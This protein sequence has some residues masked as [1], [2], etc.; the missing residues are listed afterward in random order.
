MDENATVESVINTIQKDYHESRP[1]RHISLAGAALFNTC[2]PYRRLPHASEIKQAAVEFKEVAP[3]YY[4]TEYHVSI[5]IE[6][7]DS[8]TTIDRLLDGRH[9]RC[10]SQQDPHPVAQYHQLLRET[11]QGSGQCS[12]IAQAIHRAV[13]SG[14]SRCYWSL[15]PE[16]FEHMAK[17][18]PT[19]TVIN[20]WDKDFT[21]VRLDRLSS[22]LA[23]YLGSLGVA[24]E[25][26]V[27]TCFSKSAW[28]AVEN[29]VNH[30]LMLRARF[31]KKNE[32]Q[33]DFF[34]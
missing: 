25:K 12:G 19:A 18:Y 3:A 2:L 27:S 5:N 9:D 21:Y 4:P 26:Y 30:H 6:A 16:M 24:P 10:S 22:K 8:E 13:E 1:H 34:C 29:I 31:V 15:R 23:H 11:P 7:S 32:C 33:A 14:D 17:R 28:K 20:S